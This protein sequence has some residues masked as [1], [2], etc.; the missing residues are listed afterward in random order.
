MTFEPETLESRS[1]AQTTRILD[2]FLIK[3]WA[4]YFPLAVGTR[5]R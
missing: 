4:K 2:Y 1:K 5:A 3:T